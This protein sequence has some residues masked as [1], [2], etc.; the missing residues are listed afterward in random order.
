MTETSVT[1]WTATAPTSSRASIASGSFTF[2]CRV[3]ING[4]SEQTLRLRGTVHPVVRECKHRE[5]TA[6]LPRGQATFCSRADAV[7]S[8]FT[9]SGTKAPRPVCAPVLGQSE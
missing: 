5:L 9:D 4:M 3:S 1:T 8:G 2:Y 6:Q 7:G